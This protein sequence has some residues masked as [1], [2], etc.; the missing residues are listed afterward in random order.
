M[1]DAHPDLAIPFET[2]F[3][4]TLAALG[5]T[6]ISKDRLFEVAT[7]SF[8]WPN[9]QVDAAV[10]HQALDDIP[11]Y[12]VTEGLRAFYRLCA[13]RSGK[14]RWGDKTPLTR[15]PDDRHSAAVAGGPT[16]FTSFGTVTTRRCRFEGFGSV[17]ATTSDLPRASWSR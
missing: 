12:S 16:S 8:S 7:G 15:R 3:V 9:L 14:A 11:E 4:H 17:P 6:N 1:L 13:R 10:L 5:D 2:H